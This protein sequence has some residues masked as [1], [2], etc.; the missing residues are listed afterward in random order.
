MISYI[1]CCNFGLITLPERRKRTTAVLAVTHTVHA[2]YLSG[3][4]DSLPS[5][6]CD[7]LDLWLEEAQLHCDSPNGLTQVSDL[8]HPLWTSVRSLAVDESVR[9]LNLVW[10]AARP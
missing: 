1:A 3:E 4:N 6:P 10:C 2:H 9:S 7:A 8:V 5:S